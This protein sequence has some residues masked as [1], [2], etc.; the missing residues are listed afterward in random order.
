MTGLAI[1]NVSVAYGR[2]RVI[3]DVSLPTLERGTLTALV[4]PNGAGKS[5]L[6]RAIAGLERMDGHVALDDQDLSTLNATDRARR[7][8]YM[9]QQLPPGIALG[10]LE[11]VVAALRV[12]D[13]AGTTDLLAEAHAALVR[14]GIAHLADRPLDKLSGGQRQLVAL[15][16]LIARRPQ[17]L[18]LDEPTSALDLHYQLRVMDCV[19]ELTQAHGLVAVIVLHDIS[20]A[21]RHSDQLVVLRNGGV[22]DQGPPR[23]IL[24]PGLLA[25][26]YGVEARVECCSKG[27]VQVLVD[28]PIA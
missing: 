12:S 6:L 17:V 11:G 3:E 15:A 18:L 7:M 26:V 10:V 14:V 9:P 24:T 20:M 19:R 2:H 5:T 4:G 1:R 16:Q 8:T 22:V 21:A 13:N 23:Q 25:D 27:H 28:R